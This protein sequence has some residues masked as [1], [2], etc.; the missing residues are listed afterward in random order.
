LINDDILRDPRN[1]A[2]SADGTGGN[3][4][5]SIQLAELSS[6]KLIEGSTLLESYSAL[7]SEIG[8]EKSAA[9]YSAESNKIVLDKLD[10]QKASYSGVSIDEEMTN[11]IKFQRSYDASAKLVKIADEM[12][13][14]IINMV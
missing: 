11:I 4:A 9:S 7:I 10:E 14:T 2:I 13:Q 1:I 5:L 3:G 6:K 12:L 8:N